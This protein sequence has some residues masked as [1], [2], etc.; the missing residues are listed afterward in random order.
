MEALVMRYWRQLIGT[1]HGKTRGVTF[2][3]SSQSGWNISMTDGSAKEAAVFA[4]RV[5]FAEP[6]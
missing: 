5:R 1:V 3:T 6:R 4:R 2:S